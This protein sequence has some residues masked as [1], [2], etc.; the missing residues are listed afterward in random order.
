V[1]KHALETARRIAESVIIAAISS[2]GLYLVATVYSDA[3]Y[4][5]VTIEVTSVDAARVRPW[6]AKELA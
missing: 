5:R 4:G 3:Y 6:G 2:A 1:S